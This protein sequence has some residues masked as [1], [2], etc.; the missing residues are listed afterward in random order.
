[1]KLEIA[2]RFNINLAVN[3]FVTA[4]ILQN[5]PRSYLRICSTSVTG[6]FVCIDAI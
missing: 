2:H 4:V 1:L 6:T 3:K 5:L